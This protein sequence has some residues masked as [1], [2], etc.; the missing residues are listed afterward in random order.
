VA[1]AMIAQA[2]RVDRS[3][4]GGR[5][6]DFAL[7]TG[8]AADNA[9][10]NELRWF[11]DLMDGGSVSP[12]SGKPGYQGVQRESPADAYGDLLAEAQA[13][14]VPEGLRYPWFA[15]AG[16]RDVLAQGNFPPNADAQALATGGAKVVGGGPELLQEACSRPAALLVRRGPGPAGRRGHRS[17]DG[18]RGRGKAVAEPAGVGREHSTQGGAG[19]GGARGLARITAATVRLITSAIWGPPRSLCW[20]ARTRRVFCRQCRCRPVRLV[21]DGLKV[22]PALHRLRR[23]V[24]TTEALD[25]LIVVASHHT[26]AT[27]NNP[28]PDPATQAERLRGPQLEELLHRFPERCPPVAGHA[29]STT[30]AEAGPATPVRRLLGGEHGVTSGFP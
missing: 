19:S 30:H 26:S 11:I 4:A 6:V 21:E 5:R 23:K 16:N 17:A 10:Y 8:N 28:F 24:V 3:P 2:N 18:G 27:M 12:D 9:Q 7:H 13:P 15:V 29:W 20:T 22:E 1:A 25:R 14:F